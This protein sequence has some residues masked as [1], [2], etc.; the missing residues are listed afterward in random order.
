MTSSTC[1]AFSGR[2]DV[3]IGHHRNPHGGLDAAMVSYSAS[4]VY[5]AGARTAVHGTARHAGRSAVR[6]MRRRILVRQAPAGAQFQCD[7]HV[8][9]GRRPT[10]ASRICTASVSSCISAEP[11]HLVADLLGRA[12]HV[13]VDDL[14]AVVDVVGGRPRPSSR[15]GAGNLHR[16]RVGLHRRGWR[17]ARSW[18]CRRAASSR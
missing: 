13:D 2:R 15:I 17:G 3:A 12:T 6:A 8:V 1:L 14:R 4:P 10:T 16:D 9:G 7:R 5:L 11:A 18:R